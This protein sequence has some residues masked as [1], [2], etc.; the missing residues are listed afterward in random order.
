MI[1][2]EDLQVGAVYEFSDCEDFPD[3]D[4]GLGMFIEKHA[5]EL[6]CDLYEMDNGSKWKYIRYCQAPIAKPKPVFTQE[7]ADDGELPLIGSLVDIEV[8]GGQ[9]Y[10]NAFVVYCTS[11]NL[12]IKHDLGEIVL[13]TGGCRFSPAKTDREKV[14]DYC[15]KECASSEDDVVRSVFKDVATK[16]YD[17]GLINEDKILKGQSND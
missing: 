11:F 6:H 1:K 7:M 12:I 4:I 13:A 10:R 17:T 15:V 14:I 5:R 16:L 9:Y 3:G 8:S 2:D